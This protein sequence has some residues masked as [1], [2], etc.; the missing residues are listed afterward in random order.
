MLTSCF[1]FEKEIQEGI[2]RCGIILKSKN[3]ALYQ[4]IRK[5]KYKAYLI[6]VLY[7]FCMFKNISSSFEIEYDQKKVLDISFQ[8]LYQKRNVAIKY[9]KLAWCY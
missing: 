4:I 6:H 5:L 3:Y 8:I 1:N 7:H 2:P 9:V